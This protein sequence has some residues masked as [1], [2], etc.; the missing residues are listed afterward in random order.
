[1]GKSHSQQKTELLAYLGTK[2]CFLH[3]VLR[4][5]DEN[6]DRKIQ[7]W[8]SDPRGSMT[9]HIDLEKSNLYHWKFYVCVS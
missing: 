1:M 9:E 4:V 7:V 5:E 8:L 3:Y 2:V 6:M